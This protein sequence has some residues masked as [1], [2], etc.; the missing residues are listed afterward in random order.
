MEDSNDAEMK[1]HNT[2]NLLKELGLDSVAEQTN[3]EK[4][5]EMVDIRHKIQENLDELTKNTEN[6]NGKQR[7]DFS[8]IR[9]SD[10][11]L[12]PFNVVVESMD[13]NV[14][15]Y[16]PMALGLLLRQMKI[17]GVRSLDRRG[18]NK[19]SITFRTSKDANNF[20]DNE[21]FKLKG[22]KSFIPSSMISCKGLIR[23]VYTNLTEQ[24]IMENIESSQKVMDVRRVTRRK[25]VSETSNDTGVT[26]RSEVYEP[27]SSII[28][29]FAGKFLPKKVAICLQ[30]VDVFVYI[31]P[32]IY[33]RKCQRYGHSQAQCR[34]KG[35]C[36]G[37]LGEHN[38]E[39]CK[40]TS[41]DAESQCPHCKTKHSLFSRECPEYIRQKKIKEVMVLENISFFEA[42]K[43]VRKTYLVNPQEF[44]SL[45]KPSNP[46]PVV[47]TISVTD[48][49][50]HTGY[51]PTLNYAAAA[52][53]SQNKRKS[54]ES[55]GYDRM[56][57]KQCLFNF[58]DTP[59]RALIPQRNKNNTP[60]DPLNINNNSY[61]L[62]INM[63][64]SNDQSTSS[65]EE[66][67]QDS[68]IELLVELVNNVKGNT[69]LGERLISILT[70]QLNIH[71][72]IES[73][74]LK[75]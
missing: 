10:R 66:A 31:P 53:N 9:F 42:N 1:E 56:A 25:V 23:N 65:T 62:K 69:D 54:L 22:F 57:H 7:I 40:T 67:C 32:V 39:E 19:V 5:P 41:S 33:C 55:P 45:K 18:A 46:L 34:G 3:T 20:L 37:C 6:S 73:P 11:D 71:R 30:P 38:T 27:T 72:N 17:G 70:S 8:L 29:T 48:R 26:T 2:N 49:R 28:V 36:A 59:V 74:I 75:L 68:A 43:K 21:Q 35:R 60:L 16:H 61:D 51:A 14:G 64:G 47:D 13:K 24:Q 4:Q 63:R 58:A 44:P 12:G 52:S 50:Q 15:N